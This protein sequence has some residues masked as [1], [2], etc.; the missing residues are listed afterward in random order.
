MDVVILKG[1]GV[2]ILMKEMVVLSGCGDLEEDGVVI[3][4]GM[5]W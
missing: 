3:W 4:K 1:D 2:V 5:V